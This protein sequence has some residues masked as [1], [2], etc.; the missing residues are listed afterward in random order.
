LIVHSARWNDVMLAGID[1][2]QAFRTPDR[3]RFIQM[4][5]NYG[6]GEPEVS[7]ARFSANHAA[8]L[9]REDQMHPYSG[10]PGNVKLRD[11]H[12][13]HLPWPKDLLGRHF[14]ATFRLRVTLSYFVAPN[15]SANNALGGSRYRYGG[16][17]LR[18]LVRHK[19]ES[20]SRFQSRLEKAAGEANEENGEAE[21]EKIRSDA[22]WA[23]GSKLCGKGGSLIQDIWQGSAAELAQMDRI[24]IYPVKGWWA[25]R[26]FPEGSDWANCHQIPIRYSLIV[27]VET[28][29]NIPVYNEIQ[30]LISI[31]V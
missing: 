31:S 29:Q 30:N 19:E 5:R 15:P 8:T 11:C 20:P 27:S 14:D 28:E 4:L 16:C 22:G 3:R 12:I 24:A 9:I 17:L 23:L 26:K 18:F 6:F 1:P 21:V 2:H 7:R 13:H 25:S 10:K